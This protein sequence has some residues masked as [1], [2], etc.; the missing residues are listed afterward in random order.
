[1]RLLAPVLLLCLLVATLAAQGS[2]IGGGNLPPTVDA[3]ANRLVALGQPI[4]L[5]ARV[6]D[7]GKPLPA[8]LTRLWTLVSGPGAVTFADAS[9]EDTSATVT[10]AGAYVLRL[11]VSDGELSG[12]DDVSI[13]VR[14]P[15]GNAAPV[16]T[17]QAWSTRDGMPVVL[18]LAATDADGD[19][20]TWGGITAPAHGTISGTAPNLAYTPAPGYSGGD[21]FAITAS[22]GIAISAPASISFTVSP[23]AAL[24]GPA[25]GAAA[26]I[27]VRL[28]ASADPGDGSVSLRWIPESSPSGY[29][30]RR[31]TYAANGWTTIAGSL[32]PGSQGLLDATAVAGQRYEYQ[33]RRTSSAFADGYGYAAVATGAALDGSAKALVLLV[34]ASQAGALATEIDRLVRDLRGEGWT[35]HRHDVPRDGAVADARALI[36]ADAAADPAVSHVILLGRVGVPYS[37]DIYPD[38][39]GDHQGAWPADVYYG[40]TSGTTWTDSSVNRTGTS[41]PNTP[42]D[43]RFDNYW[44]YAE[45][46]VG[47]IDLSG[48]GGFGSDETGLLRRYLDRDHAWRSGQTVVESRTLV[49]DNF[50]AFSGE[51]FAQSGLRNGCVL[52][53][54]GSVTQGDWFATLTTGSWLV[55]Y[56][57]GG[58]SNQSVSGVGSTSDFRAQRSGA[59]FTML[60]GSYLGDWDQADNVLRAPLANDGLGLATV[61][62]GRPNTFWHRMALGG[63]IGDSVRI[64][65]S[66]AAYDYPPTGSSAQYVHIALM[67]DPTLVLQPVAPPGSLTATPSGSAVDLAWTAAPAASLGYHVYRAADPAGPFTRL[68]SI[69]IASTSLHDAGPGAGTWQYQ[70]RAVH[71]VASV[72]ATYAAESGAAWASATV[73]A[74]PVAGDADGDGSVTAA[75]LAVVRGQFGRTGTAI[76]PGSADLDGNG[77]IDAGD[78]ALVTR[79]LTP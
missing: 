30:V 31:K 15:A 45:L 77:R 42:G 7:D 39:H 79:A 43:G 9:M 29:S 48:M 11:S 72:S 21:S 10:V 25:G 75:D 24:S 13:T 70:V 22:D 62:A 19:P 1:M 56:G 3:G 53:G 27:V 54:I 58:G 68:T 44:T 14:D 51:Y 38:G 76:S 20:L 36:L 4:V 34:D 73:S 41:R 5:D 40:D 67:G 66:A 69:P 16:V 28:E 63:T 78:L 50:G 2:D 55:G 26:N 71:L 65:Q 32:A 52:T 17:A 8:V 37:G 6:V 74:G 18:R 23:P 46:A 33:V 64:S 59:V 12:S 61:W 47:R 35:V 60:F 49:D 57:C